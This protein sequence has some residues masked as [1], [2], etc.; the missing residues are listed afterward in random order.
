MMK[1]EVGD[2]ELAEG[3]ILKKRGGSHMG[4]MLTV[5]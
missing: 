2:D 4:T 5:F 1:H 3:K